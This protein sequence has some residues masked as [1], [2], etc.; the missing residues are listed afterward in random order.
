MANWFIVSALVKIPNTD[1][2]QQVL[3]MPTHVEDI[4]HHMS[5]L[6]ALGFDVIDIKVLPW[7]T[8]IIE[9]R[10]SDNEG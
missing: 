7:D 10:G 5:S 2:S 3:R 6:T 1:A 8:N 9:L 4:R